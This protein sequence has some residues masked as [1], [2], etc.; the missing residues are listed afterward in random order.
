MNPHTNA[1]KSSP[2]PNG[3]GHS[4][5]VGR[6]PTAPDLRLGRAGERP[7]VDRVAAEGAVADLLSALGADFGDHHLRD[8]PRRV[9]AA[10]A[11]VLTPRAFN[12]TTFPNEVD[13]NELVL[14]HW[15][16]DQLD[17]KGVGVVLDAEHIYMTLRGV[18]ASGS[19]TVTSALRGLL[20]DDERS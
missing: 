19:R 20:R 7:P 1:T 17:P 10:F 16:D 9:E 3:N 14:A 2:H 13:H 18:E 4:P 15:L 11:E 5:A 8:T 12:P 6:A